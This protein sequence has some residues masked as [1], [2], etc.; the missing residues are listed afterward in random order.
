[1]RCNFWPYVLTASPFQSISH[2]HFAQ[3]AVLT[4]ESRDMSCRNETVTGA[5]IL[6]LLQSIPAAASDHD[7]SIPL[8]GPGSLAQ[9]VADA[10][11]EVC[12]YRAFALIVQKWRSDR[13]HD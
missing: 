1:M 9:A 12:C 11:L 10:I 4:P 2:R 13:Y 6:E 5:R 3:H 8:A 7:F